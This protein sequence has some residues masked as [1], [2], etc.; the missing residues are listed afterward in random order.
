MRETKVGKTVLVTSLLNPREVCKREVG[1]LFMNRWHVE[2]DL[3]NV[4]DTLGMAMLSCKSPQ[5]CAKELWV[6]ML[7]CNL[8]RLLMAQAAAQA[9]V[10][11]REL[12]FKHTV[13]VW[14]AWSHKQF[15]S[16]IPEDLP[17]LSIPH[18]SEPSGRLLREGQ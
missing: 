14:L 16:D 9:Q 7:A 8:I 10:S 15:L 3:R 1:S 12:S 6:Y 4:K 13:Q 17:A 11:P 2:L 18:I 5:M